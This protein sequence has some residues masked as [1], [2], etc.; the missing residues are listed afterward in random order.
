MKSVQERFAAEEQFHD[1]WAGSTS[2]DD[3]DIHVVNESCTAPEMRHITKTLGDLRGRTLLDVGAGLGE[4]SVYFATRGAQV[5][6]TDISGAM[7]SQVEQLATRYGVAVETHKSTAEDLQLAGRQFDV[8][9]VGNLL[10]H[11]DIDQTLRRLRDAVAPGGVLVSW[12]PVAYNPVINV[13]RR[14]ASQVRTVDEHPFTLRDLR[15]FRKYFR[16]VRTRWCWLTT[17]SIFVLMYLAQRRN[18]NQ[19][20]YWKS[21][22]YEGK[23]WRWLYWPLAGLDRVLLAVFPFLRPLCWNVVVVARDPVITS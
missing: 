6:A 3:I 20:R 12:D 22:L 7:L 11:V 13:Y 2:V 9:Y 10:H 16:T 21:V 17:L 15:L 5:T 4:A 1:Q 14:M 8:V 18:P 19:E 23:K